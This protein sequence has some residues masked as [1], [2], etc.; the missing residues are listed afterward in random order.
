[1]LGE[2]DKYQP[3]ETYAGE[4]AAYLKALVDTALVTDEMGTSQ[5]AAQADSDI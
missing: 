1:M 2:A 3:G 5:M 4:Y